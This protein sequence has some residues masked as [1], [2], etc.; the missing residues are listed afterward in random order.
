M[1]PPIARIV[2][3]NELALFTMNNFTQR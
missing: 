2:F 3:I 1:L